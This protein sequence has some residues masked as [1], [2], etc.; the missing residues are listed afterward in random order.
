MS[1]APDE[2]IVTADRPAVPPSPRRPIGNL[3]IISR[4][5]RPR[6][7]YRRLRLLRDP[8]AHRDL[9]VHGYHVTPP[10]LDEHTISALTGAFQEW[11]DRCP[12]SPD[13]SFHSSFEREPTEAGLFARQQVIRHLLPALRSQVTDAALLAASVFQSK[14]PGPAG[15]LLAHQDSFLV[16]EAAGYGLNAW[17]ALTRISSNDGPLFMLPG[18]H[19]YANWIRVSTADDDLAGMHAVIERGARILEVEPGQ[20]VWFDSATIHGSLVNRGSALRLA[21]SALAVPVSVPITVPVVAPGRSGSGQPPVV[22][23]RRIDPI[24]A[25]GEAPPPP[26]GNAPLV[27]TVGLDRLAFSPW[28]LR[29]AIALHRLRHSSPPGAAIPEESLSGRR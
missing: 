16:D 26:I 8:I 14:P 1:D 11:V 10:V 5:L 23:L 27:G 3:G 17:V 20:V 15:G 29:T 28:A 25:L 24:V 7:G 6:R 19:R 21:V 22:E 13:G 18:S 4:S 9:A 2:A 12:P